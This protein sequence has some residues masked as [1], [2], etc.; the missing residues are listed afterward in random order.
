M[1]SRW[2]WIALGL[3]L[4]AVVWGS[5]SRFNERRFPRELMEAN[6]KIASSLHQLA[7]QHLSTLAAQRPNEAEAVCLLG[8]CEEILG[9]FHAAEAS[10]VAAFPRPAR[11]IMLVRVSPSRSPS[12][13]PGSRPVSTRSVHSGQTARSPRIA[14]R[15]A[16]G[17]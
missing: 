17:R 5:W 4:I 14:G 13:R 15:S 6:R 11:P 3:G 16:I 1:R 9:H 10:L 2:L 7:R 8:L 12:H